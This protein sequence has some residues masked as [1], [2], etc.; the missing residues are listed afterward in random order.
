MNTA[1]LIEILGCVV[2]QAGRHLCFT[3][4]TAQLE[5]KARLALSN[6]SLAG[7]ISTLDACVLLPMTVPEMSLT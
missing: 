7:I 4:E 6:Q 1:K 2:T 5:I 3:A